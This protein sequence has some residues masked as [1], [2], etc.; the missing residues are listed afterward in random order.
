MT[1]LPPPWCLQWAASGE[2]EPQDRQDLFLRLTGR[3]TGLAGHG[4]AIAVTAESRRLGLC[5][6]R[7]NPIG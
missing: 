6:S 7:L 5:R 4:L 3:E 2:L 1:P